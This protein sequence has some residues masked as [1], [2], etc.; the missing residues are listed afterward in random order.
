MNHRK[1][2]IEERNN[3]LCMNILHSQVTKCHCHIEYAKSQFIH[4]NYG[5]KGL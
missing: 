4:F 1:K 3:L 2:E 5:M